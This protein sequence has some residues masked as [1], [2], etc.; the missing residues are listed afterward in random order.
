[1]EAVSPVLADNTDHDALLASSARSW[2]RMRQPAG[3]GAD[4]PSAQKLKSSFSVPMTLPR[5]SM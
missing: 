3:P 4:A 5:N 2:R 1:M